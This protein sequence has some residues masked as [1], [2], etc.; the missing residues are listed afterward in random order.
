[1]YKS[2]EDVF[3]NPNAIF[4]DPLYEIHNPVQ[5][6]N[7][8][9]DIEDYEDFINNLNSNAYPHPKDMYFHNTVNP[10]HGVLK[11]IMIKY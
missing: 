6:C 1:M 2:I 5:A 4:N 3:N 10:L 8:E 7:F 9:P 11:P